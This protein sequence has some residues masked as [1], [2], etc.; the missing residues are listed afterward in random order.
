MYLYYINMY[1]TYIYTCIIRS[2]KNGM[3]CIPFYILMN[4]WGGGAV[5]GG[6]GWRW[7]WGVGGL[8]GGGWGWEEGRVGVGGWGW[9]FHVSSRILH[10]RGNQTALFRQLASSPI[11][12]AQLSSVNVDRFLTLDI[13]VFRSHLVG[14]VGKVRPAGWR[15][16]E[17][18][19][20]SLG[21]CQT[22]SMFGEAIGFLLFLLA[23]TI[24][25]GFPTSL[26]YLD[27]PVDSRI[28]PPGLFSPPVFLGARP[29]H[30]F[31]CLQQTG[32]QPS[33]DLFCSTATSTAW[34]RL[35]DESLL[36]LWLSLWHPEAPGP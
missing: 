32:L 24:F 23:A 25:P 36:V 35:R 10:L 34:G 29:T 3:R 16:L 22:D 7:G 9:A 28:P 31:S 27:C 12:L 5:V 33:P 1:Y 20:F 13:Q 19:L 8:V 15:V 2:W 14:E 30:I 6:G 18:F 11:F 26:L 21:F 4:L 17:D